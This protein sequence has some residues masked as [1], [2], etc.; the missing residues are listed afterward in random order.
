MT[1]SPNNESE[2]LTAFAG[3]LSG[4]GIAGRPVL[5]A[6]AS[7]YVGPTA[8]AYAFAVEFDAIWGSASPDVTNLRPSVWPVMATGE[9]AVRSPQNQQ[10][11]TMN[12]KEL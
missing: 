11:T 6:N 8:A 3:A 9:T 5:S 2:F 4:I 10:T 1:F 7:N 12:A